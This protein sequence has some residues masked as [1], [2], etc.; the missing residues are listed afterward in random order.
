MDSW[1]GD[2]ASG[3][4]QHTMPSSPPPPR[5]V[6]TLG[7]VL[8]PAFLATGLLLMAP[9][10][11]PAANDAVRQAALRDYIHGMTAEIAAAEVGPAGVPALLALL[12]DPDFPRRDNVVAFLTYLGGPRATQALLAL[13]R[14]PPAPVTIPEEDRALLL[15]PQAL[16]HIA[17]RGHS[18]A[19]QALLAMTAD[20]A[21]GEVLARAAAKAPGPEALRDDLLEMA[22][23]GLAFSRQADAR[24]RITEIADGTVTPAQGGRALDHAAER[25]LEL[26]ESLER[27]GNAPGPP[28]EPIASASSAASDTAPT[29]HQHNLDYVNHVDHNDPITD[30]RLD[31]V[32]AAANVLIGVSDFAADVAC[33]NRLA[34]KGTGGTF[35]TMGD[36]LDI[37]DNLSEQIDVQLVSTARAKVVRIINFCGAPGSNIIGCSGV[38]GNFMMLVRKTN[39]TSEA[40]LWAH[41]YGHN[42]GLNHNAGS[43]YIMYASNTG[44]NNA[45]NATECDKLHNPHMLTMADLI[46]I[47]PCEPPVCGNATCEPLEN[48]NNCGSDCISGG[49][50]TCGNLIC[51][52]GDGEDCLSCA[53]DCN[54]KQTGSQGSRFCCGDGDGQNPVPCTDTRCSTMGYQCTTVPSPTYCCGDLTCEDPETVFNCEPDC[55]A[56]PTQGWAFYGTAQGGTIDFTVSGVMLQVVTTAGMTDVQVAAAVAAAING[57]ATLSGMGITAW[58]SGNTVTTTGTIDSSTINDPGLSHGM[59]EIPALSLGGLIMALLLL[60]GGLALRGRKRA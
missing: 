54:G 4:T 20:G 8:A 19:L 24:A 58:T 50:A 14:D 51:E 25:A 18:A 32:F 1:N 35:G 43:Q 5:A 47:G 34:R 2:T 6:R 10:L 3:D 22:L 53:M 28:G 48:C 55:G 36:G 46:I 9:A 45:L 13:L 49:G 12:A 59:P 39:L 52:A 29:A 37:V 23:R 57:D 16:G 17:S 11:S 33:C 42:T 27:P 26:L 38:S 31:Q 40:I 60:A 7:R 30:T 15:A 56:P 21:G 44:A 41:E